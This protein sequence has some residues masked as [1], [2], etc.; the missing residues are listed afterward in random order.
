MIVGTGTGAAQFNFL[1]YE[2]RTEY[3]MN[4]SMSITDKERMEISL[5]FVRG[6]DGIRRFLKIEVR[7]RIPYPYLHS[8]V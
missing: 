6:R 4:L 3:G 7:V 2:V 5:I 1:M 8:G